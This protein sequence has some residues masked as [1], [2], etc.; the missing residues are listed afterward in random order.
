MVNIEVIS[1]S[2]FLDLYAANLVFDVVNVKVGT[3]Q[4][5]YG[6]VTEGQGLTQDKYKVVYAVVT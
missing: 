6:K 2:D 3:Q 4:R 5:I 1:A